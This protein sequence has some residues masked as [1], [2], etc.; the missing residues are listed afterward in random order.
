MAIVITLITMTTA[1]AI[2]SKI[3]SENTALPAMPDVTAGAGAKN[4]GRGSVFTLP[5]L[6]I[7]IIFCRTLPRRAQHSKEPWAMHLPLLRS[8]SST[9]LPEMS[10]CTLEPMVNRV[11]PNTTPVSKKSPMRTLMV[12]S[13]PVGMAP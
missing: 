11:L 8:N 4:R 10:T 9:P 1:G 7:G 3:T 5:L 6:R 12:D 13:M 2:V